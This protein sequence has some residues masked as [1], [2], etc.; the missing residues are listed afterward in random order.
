MNTVLAALDLAPGD[1]V[2]TSDEEHPG[3]LAPLARGARAAWGSRSGWPRSPSWPR[4]VGRAH[5]ARRLLARVLDH[6]R[7]GGRRRLAAG[8]ARCCST[9]RRASA[10]CRWTCAQ[11]GCDFYAASG[12]KWLCGP[13]GSGY[14]YVRARARRRALPRR[15]RATSRRRPARRARARSC[16]AGARALRPAASRPSTTGLGAG[17][18]RRARGAG[19]RAT[20]TRA[21]AR[22]PAR[23]PSSSRARPDRG[24][25]RAL[26]ARLVGADGPRGRDAERLGERGVVVRDLPGTPWCARRWAPGPNEDDLDGLLSALA[27]ATLRSSR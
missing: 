23:W 27:T 9:A 15:G 16:H 3:L 18:A 2:L 25:A 17:R 12:Q 24:A 7:G 1:E 26:D 14:L 8:G 13:D 11:L 20:C 22:W 5:Q 21:A 6:R 10:R 4:A 19:L